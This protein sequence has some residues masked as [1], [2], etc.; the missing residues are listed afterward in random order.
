MNKFNKLI[1]LNS[2][3]LFNSINKIIKQNN[4][5]LRKEAF[6]SILEFS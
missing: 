3:M 1:K 5:Y 4:K 6:E 2:N